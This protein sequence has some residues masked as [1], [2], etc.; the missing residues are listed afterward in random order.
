[1]FLNIMANGEIPF[2]PYR[3]EL[4]SPFTLNHYGRNF[5]NLT[6]DP[7]K[8]LRTRT[9]PVGSLSVMGGTEAL[10]KL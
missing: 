2:A 8:S 10:G 4:T 1:M 5:Y 9:N 3:E 7:Q 6:Y